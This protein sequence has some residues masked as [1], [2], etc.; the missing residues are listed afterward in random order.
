[1]P[2]DARI[3]LS[4]ALKGGNVKASAVVDKLTREW[5]D[6]KLHILL[7]E[8]K[9]RYTGENGV[10]FHPM[11]VRSMAGA[12]APGFSIKSNGPETFTW[13]FDLNKISAAIKQH[14]DEYEA[15]GHR[16]NTFTF[17]E[18][19]YEINPKDLLVAAFRSG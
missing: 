12:D 17:A 13:D 7:V 14:L 4:A 19:K 6:L 8:G 5:A 18:K 10:R 3:K 1:M 11:V 9:L 16:G 15:G 2:A